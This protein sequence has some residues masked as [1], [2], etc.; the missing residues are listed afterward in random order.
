MTS[1]NVWR[2]ILKEEQR[3][4]DDLIEEFYKA[5]KESKCLIGTHTRK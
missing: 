1:V 3:K 2:N 5:E 4:T